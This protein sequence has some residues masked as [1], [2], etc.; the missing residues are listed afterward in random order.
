M[1]KETHKTICVNAVIE[2]YLSVNIN[3]PI[4]TAEDD[5]NKFIYNGNREWEI[6]FGFDHRLKHGDWRWDEADFD[7]EFD[8][9]AIDMSDE[10]EKTLTKD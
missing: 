6:F 3:V 1:N 7:K 4:A 9:D 2:N 5:I 8:P 10:I